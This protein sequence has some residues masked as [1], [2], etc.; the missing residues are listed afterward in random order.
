MLNQVYT[1]VSKG[2][3]EHLKRQRVK[4]ELQ[5]YRYYMIRISHLNE[6]LTTIEEKLSGMIPAMK[7]GYKTG[8]T[9]SGN[10]IVAAC[11]DRDIVNKELEYLRKHTVLV[12][13]WLDLVASE[14]GEDYRRV[15]EVYCIRENYQNVDKCT[16]ELGCVYGRYL[17]RMVARAEATIL[18]NSSM[19]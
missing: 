12:D 16:R 5:D 6:R 3:L 14:L 7:Y 8:S 19:P 9:K 10:W 17:L 15:L 1:R 13:G 18:Q 2:E 11:F 4:H